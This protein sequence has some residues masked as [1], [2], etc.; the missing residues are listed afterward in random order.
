M[1]V[2]DKAQALLDKGPSRSTL[3]SVRIGGGKVDQKVN[4]YLDFF[5]YVTTIPG[6]SAQTVAAVGQ[7]HQGIYRETPGGILYS[8]PFTMQ[9]IEN[10]EYLTYYGIRKWFDEISDNANQTSRPGSTGRAIRMNYYND[11]VSNIQLTKLEFP[12]DAKVTDRGED[13]N[14]YYKS[15]VKVNFINA[16]PVKIGEINLQST[17]SD[18][19]VI[20]Q[21][22]F[23]YE[24][25]FI[26]KGDGKKLV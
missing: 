21:A 10:S 2:Y 3:Y 18:Q 25:Y 12:A 9:I 1:S 14:K 19:P 22:D 4:D 11:I 23:T 15:P 16:Y 20:W 17:S 8:K 24:S 5:C 6:I 7:E 26:D 13:L